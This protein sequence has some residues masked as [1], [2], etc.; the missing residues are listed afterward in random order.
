MSDVRRRTLGRLGVFLG[1]LASPAAWA[2]PWH[3][4]M[5]DADMVK[6][7]ER[8]MSPLPDGVMSQEHLLTPIAYRRNFMRGGPDG[9]ALTNPLDFSDGGTQA[10]GQKMYGVY[11]TPCHGDGV[12]LGPV[13]APGRYPGVAVLGGPDGRLKARSDGWVY[14]TIRNGGGLMPGYG[15]AMNDEEMWAI[16]GWMRDAIPDSKAPVVEPAGDDAA[17]GAPQ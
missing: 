9:E 3:I 17:E 11:C 1:L 12:V 16:V 2:L 13:A 8:A 4:D 10:L 5:A 15:H 6:A 7:Y 14:L